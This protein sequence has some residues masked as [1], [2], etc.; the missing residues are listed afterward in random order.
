MSISKLA[1]L[2]PGFLI[3]FSLSVYAKQDCPALLGDA[4]MLERMKN[5]LARTM[6]VEIDASHKAPTGRD[7]LA[8]FDS[9][10]RK[11]RLMAGADVMQDHIN[12]HHEAVHVTSDFN[13]RSSPAPKT[14][15][16]V[17]AF[18]REEEEWIDEELPP[19][20]R[21]YFV[22]DES[23][24]QYKSALYLAAIIRNQFRK[25][26]WTETNRPNNANWAFQKSD[27][28]RQASDKLLRNFDR[29]L[30]GYLEKGQ[31]PP[32]VA[33][34]QYALDTPHLLTVYIPMPQPNGPPIYITV[35]VYLPSV[36]FASDAPVQMYGAELFTFALDA[37]DAARTIAN[38]PP[39]RNINLD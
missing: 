13:F 30:K 23:K 20:Y 31:V 37:M 35:P 27:L 7:S 26:L 10:E 11:V 24:A 16:W 38:T 5:G 15:A 8:V 9:H 33:V 14:A 21:S 28:I 4:T 17:I 19:N 22:M 25:G 2:L 1:A 12:I 18:I 3:L 6:G 36:S 32:D 39:K 34:T 29:Y